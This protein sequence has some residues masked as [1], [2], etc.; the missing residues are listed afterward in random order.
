MSRHWADIG[1]STFVAGIWLL[2]A[3]HRLFGRWPFR[4]LLY[5]V[6]LYYWLSSRSARHASLEYLRQLQASDAVFNSQP[7]HWQSIQHFICF[8]ET[9]LDKM[10]ASSGRLQADRLRFSGHEPILAAIKAGRGGIIV[11]AHMGCLELMQAAATWRA[12]FA[13]TVLVHTAHAERFNRILKRLSPDSRM[14][15]L[16][17]TAFS[18][19]V[20]MQLAERVAAGEFIA[21]AGDRVPVHGDRIV[22]IPFLGR[23]A[24]LPT[25]PYLLAFL[26]GCP[27]YQLACLH[28]G[29]GYH[30][31]VEVLAER[32]ELPRG[33]RQ[34]ALEH[35][36]TRFAAWMQACLRESPYDWFNFFP[37][38]DQDAHASR[39]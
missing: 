20:A 7:G 38:W 18:P 32:V 36:A 5:P 3:V 31:R 4:L 14:R 15:L 11:T 16:Q 9:L 30:A 24:P 17:V 28:E 33:D 29:A 26:I 12:G 6:V 8:G 10:L 2:Y 1:E 27:V 25:G 21:I 35:Y 34:A 39:A 19:A 22:R 13:L 37:F 23:P